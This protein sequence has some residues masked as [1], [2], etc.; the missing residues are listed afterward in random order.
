MSEI[1]S[2]EIYAFNVYL[3]SIFSIIMYLFC[4]IVPCNITYWIN[5]ITV[6]I[7]VT[8]LTLILGYYLLS[9]LWSLENCDQTEDSLFK[10]LTK[11][12]MMVEV[13]YKIDSG[14]LPDV[15]DLNFTK[16]FIE[17]NFCS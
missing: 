2:Q 11:E 6:L 15:G 10:P 13:D 1:K 9:L 16:K 14:I 8:I 7:Y 17:D 3:I 12:D 5:A 4:S